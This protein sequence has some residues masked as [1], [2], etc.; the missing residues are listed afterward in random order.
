MSHVKSRENVLSAYWSNVSAA[1][2]GKNIYSK[3]VKRCGLLYI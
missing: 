1:G 2:T 3:K